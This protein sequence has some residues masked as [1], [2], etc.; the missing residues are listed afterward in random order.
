ETTHKAMAEMLAVIKKMR[1]SPVA[2][3][4]LKTAKDA[5]INR[6]V[7]QFTTPGAVVGN[8]IGLDYFG[9][10]PNFYKNYL[11]NV[12]KVTVEDVF[13]VAKVYLK[14]DNLTMVVVGNASGF[15]ADLSDLGSIT[16]VALTP[17]VVN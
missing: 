2:E 1:E 17:P 4:E 5:Y 10:D 13:R 11:D 15:D 3:E 9:R 7:F 16:K 6:F 12:R 8:L 14:P